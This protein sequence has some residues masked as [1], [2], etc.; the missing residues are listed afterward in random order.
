VLKGRRVVSD[1]ADC[2][3]A[4]E[5]EERPEA[6]AAAGIVVRSVE[7]GSQACGVLAGCVLTGR[8]ALVAGLAS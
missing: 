5:E 6:L 8:T 2:R 1:L 3:Y 4:R 7:R